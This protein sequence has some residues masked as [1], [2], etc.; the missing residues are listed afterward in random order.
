LS[1]AKVPFLDLVALH[2]PLEAQLT[3]AAAAVIESGR[4]VLGSNCLAFEEEFARHLGARRVVGVASGLDALTLVLAAWKQRGRLND[5]DSVIVPANTY[6]ATVLAIT[7]QGLNPVFVEPDPITF[8][9]DPERLDATLA[10]KPRAMIVVH[11]YGQVAD[12]APIEAFCRCHGLLLLEDCAHAHGASSAGRMVG[13]F[14]DAGA[15]S[16]YPGKNLG[17][18]GDGG[19]VATGDDTLYEDLRALRNYGSS[20]KY[21][22]DFSGFNSRLDEMQAAFLR[23]K[24]PCLDGWNRRRRQVAAA[25][26]S[27]IVNAKLRLPRGDDQATHVWHLFVLRAADRDALAAHFAARGVETL[28]HYPLPPHRQACYRERFGHLSLPITER[29]HEE[30]LS[31]PMSPTLTEAQVEQV[32]DAANSW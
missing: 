6:I 2:R 25:Y 17:A 32:I 3:A 13:T 22:N 15:F 29:I 14:G 18:L 5:G 8:N 30:V 11:L 12:M 24:L 1:D 23:V 19:A 21:F 20:R 27:R 16:F 7:N 26:R 4:F 10:E 28:V 31:L 9:L